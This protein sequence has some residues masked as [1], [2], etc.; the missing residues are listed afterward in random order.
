LPT[1]DLKLRLMLQSRA[2]YTAYLACQ[3][4]QRIIFALVLKWNL[5]HH[6]LGYSKLVHQKQLRKA[7]FLVLLSVS[8]YKRVHVSLYFIITIFTRHLKHHVKVSHGMN[9][10]A[11]TLCTLFDWSWKIGKPY[12]FDQFRLEVE[13]EYFFY[14]VS[15]ICTD[16]FLWLTHQKLD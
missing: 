11:F 2:K 9:S 12:C 8:D 14:A 1:P 16:A 15:L 6:Q 10:P 5:H 7:L 3:S 4:F 13:V